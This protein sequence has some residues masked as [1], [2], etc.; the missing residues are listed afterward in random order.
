MEK[1]G[2]KITMKGETKKE[3]ENNMKRKRKKKENGEIYIESDSNTSTSLG[4]PP[5]L[6]CFL[7]LPW[8]QHRL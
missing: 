6:Y 7:D 3:H 8:G 1:V 4:G 2:T 5:I